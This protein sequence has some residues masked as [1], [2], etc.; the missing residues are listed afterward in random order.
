MKNFKDRQIAEGLYRMEEICKKFDLNP[1]IIKYL[2][3]GKIYYSY[4]TASGMIGSIDNIEYDPKYVELIKKFESNWGGYVYHAIESALPLNNRLYHF[5]TL[6]YVSNERGEDEWKYERLV[7]DYITSY[8]IN[9]DNQ[10]L[11]EAGDVFLGGFRGPAN[12][13]NVLV[14]IS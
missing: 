6:L 3:Q 10:D 2:K 1:N 8:V 13:Y 14:R 12:D 11:S 4:I 9:L 7:D 5:F